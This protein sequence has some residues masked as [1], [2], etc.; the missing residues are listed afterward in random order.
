[1]LEPFEYKSFLNLVLL[2]RWLVFLLTGLRFLRLREDGPSTFATGLVD[3]DLQRY[4]MPAAVAIPMLQAEVL[5]F[6]I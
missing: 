1:M 3:N 5:P 4:P 2:F 6:Q